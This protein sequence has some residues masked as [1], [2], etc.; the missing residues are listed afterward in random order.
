MIEAP[1]ARVMV[2]TMA[3]S[4]HSLF[5]ALRSL[6]SPPPPRSRS[7]K[8]FALVPSPCSSCFASLYCI[9]RPSGLRF[10]LTP[11]KKGA[12]RQASASAPFVA[13]ALGKLS[14]AELVPVP[15]GPGELD[16]KFTSG[17]G[18]YGVYD[19][20]GDLQFIGISR[21]IASSIASHSKFVPDLCHSV[22]VIPRKAGTNRSNLGPK[23]DSLRKI[24][25]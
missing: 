21:N 20:E 14:D 18:V 12:L 1:Y 23:P 17:A 4:P 7:L 2:A 19:K 11:P 3:S 8:T 10:P 22:K 24:T 6:P 25:L 9:Y 5:S 13:A 16:G 15:K